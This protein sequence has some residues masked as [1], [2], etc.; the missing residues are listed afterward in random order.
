MG[1]YMPVRLSYFIVVMI[2]ST[3][4][5]GIVWSSDSVSPTMAVFLRMFIALVL[6]ALVMVIARIR[7]PVNRDAFKLYIYSAMGIYGGMIL[8]YFAASSVP[9]GVISLI[10]GLAPIFSGI[11]AQRILNEPKFSKAKLLA[12]LMSVI[13]LIFICKEQFAGQSFI[14]FGLILVFAAMCCFSLSSVMVKT[15][16]IAIHPMATTIGA[17]AVVTPLFFLTWLLVDGTFEPATWSTRAIGAII[18]LGVFGSLLGFLAY[19]HVLQKLQAST[20]ALVTLMTPGFAIA[21]GTLLNN[22]PLSLD[23]LIGA[24]IILLSLGLFQFG[25]KLLK[26]TIK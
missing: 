16:N 15:V 21:L 24:C 22:E 26:V 23:L 3:T 19:F 20:V 9:S 10:F 2:W 12:L 14:N 5:L 11:L 1:I 4:P 18:Y 8:T 6:G 17:L 25:D 13:G 7:L